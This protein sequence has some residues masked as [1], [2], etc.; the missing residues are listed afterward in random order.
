MAVHSVQSR[1][2]SSLTIY[3]SIAVISLVAIFFLA[4][5]VTVHA[6]GWKAVRD[7]CQDRE[8]AR[9]YF[10]LFADS[11]GCEDKLLDFE[12]TTSTYALQ[13]LE[14]IRRLAESFGGEAPSEQE[15]S[16]LNTTVFN[17]CYPPL[18]FSITSMSER[19]FQKKREKR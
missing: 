19:C 11:D 17:I 10:T 6:V 1:L 4:I 15:L 9:L 3:H 18:T 14:P 2:P 7:S 13:T 8:K 12:N 16:Q 5:G